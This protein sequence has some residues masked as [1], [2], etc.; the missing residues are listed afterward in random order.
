LAEGVSELPAQPL[1]V[2][3]QFAATGVGD[4]Q[5]VQQGRV[6]GALT[7]RH[8]GGRCPA[9]VIAESLD[10]GPD[11]GLGVEPGPGDPR[12]VGD[13]LERHGGAGVVELA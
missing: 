11:V 6:G 12:R 10:L 7:G 1:V 3:G 8:G 4:F 5:P 9:T 2:L 13:G